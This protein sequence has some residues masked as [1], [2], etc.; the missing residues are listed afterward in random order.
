MNPLANNDIQ[1][2]KNG[3]NTAFEEATVFTVPTHT[4]SDD[5]G[6]VIE[7]VS[8]TMDEPQIAEVPTPQSGDVC[9]PS[10]GD[11]VIIGYQTNGTAQV[12]GTQYEN[13][14]NIPTFEEGERVVGHPASNAH[15]R[16]KVDGTVHIEGDAGNTVEL[17]T[18][19]TIVINGGTEQPV[20][21]VTT[22]K[23]ADGH[24]TSISL[25]HS[26]DVFVP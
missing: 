26:P 10:E 22:T 25:T 3:Q 4:A 1:T 19:G 18:D 17:Q 16:F 15:V 2:W 24:V 6:H 8:D 13:A 9:L 14:S 5:V 12:I 7:V 21:D 11:D 23:D 20:T